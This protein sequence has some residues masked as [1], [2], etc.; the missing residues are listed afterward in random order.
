MPNYL[1]N[2]EPRTKNEALI[3][4]A[5]ISDLCSSVLR[6]FIVRPPF[7]F[8]CPTSSVFLFDFPLYFQ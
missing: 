2:E 6:P 3:I 7:S 4:V 1:I 5:P 8:F